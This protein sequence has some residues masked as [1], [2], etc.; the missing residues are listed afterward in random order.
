[1]ERFSYVY[2]DQATM[3]IDW[4][5]SKDGIDFKQGDTLTCRRA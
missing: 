1:M 3:R 5:V 2:L 4:S